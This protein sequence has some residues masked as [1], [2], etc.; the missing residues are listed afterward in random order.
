MPADKIYVDVKVKAKCDFASAAIAM[1]EKTLEK[2]I[3]G[4][5]A[6]STDAP[7]DKK[8]PQ[9][10]L[11]T[12]FSGALDKDGK[13]FS[14]KLATAILVM[15]AT[16]S[17]ATLSGSGAA[18]LAKAGKLAADDVEALAESLAEGMAKKAIDHMKKLKA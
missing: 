17:G 13:K 9:W 4:S 3:K 16:A 8:A 15:N 11:S 2:A 14:G 1:I 6:L 10:M 7:K 18:D 5:G 12:D